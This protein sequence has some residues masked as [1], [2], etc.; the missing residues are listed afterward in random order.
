MVQTK[1]PIFDKFVTAD[2]V[3]DYRFNTAI[4]ELKPFDGVFHGK[5]GFF[6]NMGIHGV[7]DWQDMKVE[8]SHGPHKS[9][10]IHM[11]CLPVVRATGKTATERT[12]CFLQVFL[13]EGKVSKSIYYFSNT[14]SWEA[15]F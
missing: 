11:D 6:Q 7:F 12:L 8:F 13:T 3:I 2:C 4:A 15:L 1:M 9:I 10:L 5:A 14:G